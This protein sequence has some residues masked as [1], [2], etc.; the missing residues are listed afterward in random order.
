MSYTIESFSHVPAFTATDSAPHLTERYHHYCTAELI[1]PLLEEGWLLSDVFSKKTR[2]RDPR[3][4]KHL[5]RL[6]H[7][8]LEFG[9]GEGRLECLINNSHDGDNKLT[10]NLGAWRIVCS[11]GL[12]QQ[13]A[14]FARLAITHTRAF[15]AVQSQAALIINK[16]PDV[17]AKIDAWRCRELQPEETRFLADSA[18]WLRW[19]GPLH[20]PITGG[21]LLSVRRDEDRTDDLWT[22]L[23]RVQENV[24]RGGFG[25]TKPIVTN[26]DLKERN[27]RVRA[28]RSIDANSRIN[29]GLWAAAE[30]IYN[31]EDLV[32]PS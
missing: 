26:D 28:V 15:E 29:R 17:V 25:Y 21:E 5:A 32:L 4:A 27:L 12:E 31:N 1:K 10:I 14:D 20:S 6:T 3:F 13:S 30:A 22:T 9:H 11:N 8:S 7:P 16:A 18:L 2:T 19:G 24:L 23:N